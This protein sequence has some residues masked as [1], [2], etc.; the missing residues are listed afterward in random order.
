MAIDYFGRTA[1]ATKRDAEFP[2]MEYIPKTR[3]ATIAQDVAA[4]VAYLRSPAGGSCRS[5]FTVGFCFGGSNSWMQTAEGHGVAGAIG[6][7]GNPGP[8]MADRSPGPLARVGDFK[9][10]ILALIAGADARGSAM[11]WSRPIRKT[12]WSCIPGRRI[13]SLTEAMNSIRTS[14]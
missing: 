10:P 9:A 14:A 13:A 1:A 5:V 7:Y 11:R 2:F 12:R 6:F 8:N 3:P 4:A